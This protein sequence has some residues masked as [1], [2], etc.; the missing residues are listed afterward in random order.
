MRWKDFRLVLLCS[1]P[2]SACQVLV[3]EDISCMHW[4]RDHMAG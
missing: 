4:Y 2:V 3:S 1:I